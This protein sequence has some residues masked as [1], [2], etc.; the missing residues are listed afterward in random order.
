MNATYHEPRNTA[1]SAPGICN[2]VE[3][4]EKV[5]A[6]LHEAVSGL[7]SRLTPVTRPMACN[8]PD[9]G[10]PR[11][12]AVERDVQSGLMEKIIRHRSAI[13][14]A[15]GRITELHGRVEL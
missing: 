13:M 5:I 6:E 1:L 15:T 2:E 4:M 14:Q 12:T 11:G 9:I 7:E 3:L 8:P 10:P